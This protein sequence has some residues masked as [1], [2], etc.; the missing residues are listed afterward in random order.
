MRKITLMCVTLLLCNICY[1]QSTLDYSK[2]Y[3]SFEDDF[4]GYGDP[5]VIGVDAFKNNTSFQNLYRIDNEDWGGQVRYRPAN[6]TMQQKGILT[7]I[8]TDV[9]DY[10]WT[11][12]GDQQVR[13]IKY[14][15]AYINLEADYS[16][17]SR[18]HGYGIAEVRMKFPQPVASPQFTCEVAAWL[19]KPGG[20][21]IDIFDVSFVDYYTPR[22]FDNTYTPSSLRDFNVQPIT[23][24]NIPDITSDF[25][26]FSTEWT[27]SVVRYYIDGQLVGSIKYDAEK[28]R[29]YPDFYDFE[30]A[31]MP[32]NQTTY[33]SGQ[34]AEIDWI[35]IW[36]RNCLDEDLIV[37]S[38]SPFN[39][40]M[41]KQPP[42][43]RLFNKKNVTISSTSL[44]TAFSDV[45]TVINAEATIINS[46]FLVDQS[47]LAQHPTEPSGIT[48]I[49]NAYFEIT[50]RACED[51][52]YDDDGD[53]EGG[54]ETSKPDRPNNTAFGTI[55]NHT[56]SS[57]VDMHN[58]NIINSNNAT[59]IGQ[60]HISS[61]NIIIYPN[62]S[63]G[64]FSIELPTRGNYDIKVMSMMGAVVY[65]SSLQ[66][67][68]KIKI[69]LD[70]QL[71]LGNYSIHI[72]GEGINY[73][74]KITT[75]K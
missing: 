6:L 52:S 11:N 22:V 56:I 28:I 38:T 35:K 45:P 55:G 5:A 10:S 26:T 50:A 48:P 72:T 24:P 23:D 14:E 71:P 32:Y 66:N 27:P 30:I 49:A 67:R 46:N 68:Q 65:H 15:S 64:S 74:E 29:T 20:T 3:I 47:T 18:N 31:L 73:I 42:S 1:C 39:I 16:D 62:P 12:P 2:Y 17:K 60:A 61:Q 13:T 4:E 40:F 7:L 43:G 53:N 75:I 21:E 19:F 57:K 63:S 69:E 34:T 9:V 58:D 37:N 59:K 33:G 41:Q 51:L 25:H 70:D 54:G 36:K 44:L 8:E